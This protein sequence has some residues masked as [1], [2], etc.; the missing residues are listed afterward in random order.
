MLGLTLLTSGPLLVLDGE[1]CLCAMSK[2][3]RYLGTQDV[4]IAY[5]SSLGEFTRPAINAQN[6]FIQGMIPNL[7]L[8]VSLSFVFSP[9]HFCQSC[10]FVDLPTLVPFYTDSRTVGEIL[11]TICTSSCEIP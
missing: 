6:I 9:S 1:A 7:R 3:M 5:S 4:E 11:N 8:F 2:S 10:V